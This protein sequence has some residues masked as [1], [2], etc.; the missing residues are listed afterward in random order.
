MPRSPHQRPRIPAP[1]WVDSRALIEAPPGVY[2]ILRPAPGDETPWEFPG[3]RNR[4]EESPEAA[5]R[6]IC[7]EQVG[8]DLEIVIGQPPFEYQYD[9]QRVWFR[10]YLCGIRA[11]EPQPRG[12]AE[13]RQVALGQMVEYH[14]EPA[15]QQV[16]NWLLAGRTQ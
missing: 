7:R 8:A 5:L 9:A 3:G 12:C 2:L 6:R 16:V 13:I 1:D 11:G 15:A 4:P 14:F 10:Y